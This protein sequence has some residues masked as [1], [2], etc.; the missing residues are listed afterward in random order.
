MAAHRQDDTP[1]GGTTPAIRTQSGLRALH[2]H[3]K[4]AHLRRSARHRHPPTGK[5]R[6]GRPDR[7]VRSPPSDPLCSGLLTGA[8]GV[9]LSG[10]SCGREPTPRVTAGGGPTWNV[11][12]PS[13][14][15]SLAQRLQVSPDVVGR[16]FA[17]ATWTGPPLTCSG[18][19]SRGSGP[20]AHRRAASV[21]AM[22]NVRRGAQSKACPRSPAAA[23]YTRS[24][25]ASAVLRS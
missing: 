1:A 12:S 16:A 4:A 14:L 11:S 9:Q 6:G 19:I 24:L 22:Q 20:S 7:F 15:D 25:S 21:V 5:V 23:G 2:S 3:R 10:A 8:G 18:L 17:A 13:I